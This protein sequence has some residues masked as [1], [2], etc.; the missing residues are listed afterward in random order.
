MHLRMIYAI[1]P[2][3]DVSPN[4]HG[5]RKG[6][7]TIDVI[8]EK[9]QAARLADDTSKKTIEHFHPLSLTS[10]APIVVRFLPQLQLLGHTF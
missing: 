7:P 9:V 10:L 2:N 6:P 8:E 1:R 5:F 4:Q 3:G